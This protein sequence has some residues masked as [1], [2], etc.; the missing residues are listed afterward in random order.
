M[1]LGSNRK[2]EVF[3]VKQRERHFPSLKEEYGRQQWVPHCFP[4]P[5]GV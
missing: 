1:G 2:Q 4:A 3:D 5:L